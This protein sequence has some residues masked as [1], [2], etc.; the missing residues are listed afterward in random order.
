M[1]ARRERGV[2]E[3]VLRARRRGDRLRGGQ[4]GARERSQVAVAG[5]GLT[6]NSHHERVTRSRGDGPV[7]GRERRGG[8]RRSSDGS[9]SRRRA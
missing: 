2:G 4:G 8:D 6:G 1:S 3:F 9:G 5:A 7:A